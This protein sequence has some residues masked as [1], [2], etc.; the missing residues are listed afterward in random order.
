LRCGYNLTFKIVREQLLNDTKVKMD[1]ENF[2]RT[3]LGKPSVNED[4]FQIFQT[5]MESD[6]CVSRDK[7]IDIIAYEMVRTKGFGGSERKLH[8]TNLPS[9]SG[10]VGQIYERKVVKTGTYK[11]G[12]IHVDYWGGYDDYEPS[13]LEGEKTHVLFRVYVKENQDGVCQNINRKYPDEFHPNQ[14][15]SGGIWIEAKNLQKIT[16]REHYGY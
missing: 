5:S 2:V 7:I 8:I 11:Q 15:N 14:S 1:V 3:S 6:Y 10:K 4:I 12:G 9:L 13:Y 16:E